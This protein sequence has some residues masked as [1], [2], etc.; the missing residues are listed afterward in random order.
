MS[1]WQRLSGARHSND[2]S[3][4]AIAERQEQK[5]RSF[6]A[7]EDYYK[8]MR[9]LAIEA[10]D[11]EGVRFYSQKLQDM[12]QLRYELDVLHSGRLGR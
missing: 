12:A 8:A 5:A 2:P 11:A 10:G 3:R 7:D 4:R 9:R 1:F 6:Q